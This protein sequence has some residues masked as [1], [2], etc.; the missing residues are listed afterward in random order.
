MITKAS[1]Q[2]KLQNKYSLHDVQISQDNR[3]TDL[4]CLILTD[5]ITAEKVLNERGYTMAGVCFDVPLS[6]SLAMN[7]ACLLIVKDVATGNLYWL[8]CFDYIIKNWTEG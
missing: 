6:I 1:I 2:E 5:A 7:G 8:S 4:S 3:V